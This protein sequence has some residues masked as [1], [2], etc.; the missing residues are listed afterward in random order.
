MQPQPKWDS[1]QRVIQSFRII[2]LS[3]YIF[4]AGI[5]PLVWGPTMIWDALAPKTDQTGI[6]FHACYP[7]NLLCS[8]KYTAGAYVMQ[9]CKAIFLTP[10]MR[11][12]ELLRP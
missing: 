3:A 10:L 9:F 1:I 11:K 8:N 2:Q 7:Q 12:V 5:A 6:D 4:H